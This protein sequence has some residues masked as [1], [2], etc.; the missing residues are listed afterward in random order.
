M[1]ARAEPMAE[2]ADADCNAAAPAGGAD[3]AAPAPLQLRVPCR[4]MAASGE[5]RMILTNDDQTSVASRQDE[6]MIRATARAHKWAEQLLA[7]KATS[8]HQLAH[9]ADLT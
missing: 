1:S 5:N 3:N 2:A 8:V 7:G 4:L 9:A 6:P